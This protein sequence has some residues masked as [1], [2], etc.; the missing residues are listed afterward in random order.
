MPRSEE[1]QTRPRVSVVMALFN[2]EAEVAEA[3]DSVLAQ[4]FDDFELIVVDDCSTDKSGEIVRR[5]SDPRIVYIRRDTNG[6]VGASR[7]TGISAARGEYLCYCDAD[8]VQLPF[9]IATEVA[10]LDS[11][12]DATMVFSDFKTYMR[13]TVISE[14]HLRARWLGPT[15]RPFETEIKEA[16]SR[17]TTAR[18]LGLPVPSEYLDRNVYQGQV[19]PLVAKMHVAWGCVQMA[20][21]D[22][23]R[24]VGGHWERA[25]A[26]EDWALTAELSKR[27]ELVYLDAPTIL[28]RVHPE[29][30]TGRPRLNIECYRDVILHTW[31]GDPEVY[32]KYKDLIDLSLGTAYALLGEFEA[33]QGRWRAAEEAFKSAVIAWPKLKRAYPNLALALLRNRLP[34]LA[35]SP[36]GRLLPAY[37]RA[38]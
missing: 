30:L 31:R 9:R 36:I 18:A 23:V 21:I 33:E 16:F 3:I 11:A 29:Q 14:S 35:D 37:L 7:N 2:R 22:R 20:R 1:Q 17:V 12:P 26:Y 6:G 32:A 19:T 10:L 25:R 15:T 5:Y 24:A 34:I 28:Y 27:W 13:G 38:R 4:T 8:D